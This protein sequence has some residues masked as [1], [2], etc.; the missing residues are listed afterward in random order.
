V[1]GDLHRVALWNI[2]R[3]T[4]NSGFSLPFT[5]FGC[6]LFTSIV[7]YRAIHITPWEGVSNMNK[8]LFPIAIICILSLFFAACSGEPQVNEQQTLAT[9]VAGTMSA[10]SANQGAVEAPATEASAPEGDWQPLEDSCSNL[11]TQMGQTLGLTISNET[12]PVQISS[13]G[14]TG[15]ACQL[16]GL[17]NGSNF[18]SILEPS[19]ALQNM[20]LNLGWSNENM[21]LPCLGHGG[22]GPGAVQA[23][24][25]NE[26]KLCETMVTLEPID[27][28]LCESVD[29]PIDSCFAILTPEQKLFTVRLTCAQGRFTPP[30][31]AAM[32]EYIKFA[33]GATTAQVQGSLSPNGF[34]QYMLYDTENHEIAINLITSGSA[35]I[36]VRQSDGTI[37]LSDKLGKTS[38]TGFQPYQDYY[39]D[40]ISQEAG[41]L[42]YTLEVSILQ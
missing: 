42:D 32:P 22:A 35:V 7:E 23:C 33:E 14:D 17:G 38:W 24:F 28:K 26:A 19:D 13:S 20:L 6:I 37:L 8:A 31:P 27:M 1:G 40:I 21:F 29:G 3:A 2:Q 25:M 15:S 34:G 9:M 10:M 39:I 18:E 5:R 12:V 11:A 16:T 30:L 41:T 36:R 4:F